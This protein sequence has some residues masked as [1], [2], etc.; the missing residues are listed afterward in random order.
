MISSLTTSKGIRGM[1]ITN[2]GKMSKNVRSNMI[3]R[4]SYENRS[5]EIE[6]VGKLVEEAIKLAKTICSLG[7]TKD[8]MVA[9]GNV[10]EL[11]KAYF[12]RKDREITDP[13]EKFCEVYPEADECR[14]YDV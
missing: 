7:N 8:C 14:E 3:C 12:D 9:W 13:L 10:D 11:S 1:K 5:P 4:C 6:K 2:G